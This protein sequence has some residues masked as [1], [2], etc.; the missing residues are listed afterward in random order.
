M[1]AQLVAQITD[2][3]PG[4]VFSANHIR[5]SHISCCGSKRLDAVI[6]S[7]TIVSSA[8]VSLDKIKVSIEEWTAR[9]PE[10]HQYNITLKVSNAIVQTG[11][12]YVYVDC[13]D[14]SASIDDGNKT[15]RLPPGEE[16]QKQDANETSPLL[17]YLILAAIVALLLIFITNI[18]FVIQR[19]NKKKA[20]KR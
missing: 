4:C 18:M 8:D 12:D 9:V 14:S 10:L 2:G 15:S 6:Y 1:I 13:S 20:D 5:N 16:D 17:I 7:A 19:F 3:C 11:T